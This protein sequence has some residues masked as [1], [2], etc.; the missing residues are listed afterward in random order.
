MYDLCIFYVCVIGVRS[1]T[2]FI[3]LRSIEN[4]NNH[5]YIIYCNK[6]NIYY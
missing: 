6:I 3:L 4:M 1:Y 2:Y 5:N